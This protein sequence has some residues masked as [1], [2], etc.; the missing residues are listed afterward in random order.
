MCVTAH[1]DDESLGFGGTLAR[2]AAEGVD[3]SVVIATRGESGRH[4]NGSEPHPGREALGRIREAEARAACAELGVRHVRFL[5]YVDR[6]LSEA[7]PI[8]AAGRV[9]AAIRDLRPQVVIT[10]DP[11]GAYGHPDHIAISQLALAGAIEAASAEDAS[12]ATW[13]PHQVQKLYFHAWTDARRDKH[14]EMFKVLESHVDGEVRASVTWPEWSVTT[15][16]EATEQWEKVWSA[17]QCHRTQIAQYGVLSGVAPEE[18][19]ALWGR[20]GYYR[21]FSL[22]NG[23]RVRETDLFEGLR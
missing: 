8:E 15:M 5:G 21:A 2:Y 6:E 19:R 1:P 14:R 4:G 23:G 10:F 22:V 18:H 16:I 9:A 17:V 3:V 13:R 12:D 11:F 7:D 20:L